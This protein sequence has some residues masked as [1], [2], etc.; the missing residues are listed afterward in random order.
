MIKLL[1]LDGDDTLWQPMSGV[2]CSD[3]T[4]DDAIGDP[5]FTFAPTPDDR[6]MVQRG[7]GPLFALHEGVRDTI[8]LA[9]ERG[10]RLA[11]CSWNHVGNID[12]ILRA[13][14]LRDDFDQVV[15][16][17]HTNKAGMIKKILAA[18]SAA[19]HEY[20]PREVLFVDDDPSDI[21]RGQAAGLNINFA[22]MG[23]PD[24]AADWNAV[25]RLVKTL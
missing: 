22:K 24:E 10:V 21:Y 14:G 19:G 1:I 17:W 2:C 16:E 4:P 9:H 7:D 5:N 20:H 8:A 18:E 6:D 12:R 11:V 3:R 13:F 25:Q 15:A 23:H